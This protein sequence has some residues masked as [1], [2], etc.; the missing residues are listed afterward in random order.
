MLINLFEDYN[1]KLLSTKVY[2]ENAKDREEFKNFWNQYKEICKI[3][4]N[5]LY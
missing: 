4:R 2:W 1:V 3:K 5:K